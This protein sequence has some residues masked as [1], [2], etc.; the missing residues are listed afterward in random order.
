MNI[1]YIHVYI[2]T[3]LKITISELF[4]YFVLSISDAVDFQC[5]LIF[6]CVIYTSTYIYIFIVFIYVVFA[7]VL[8]VYLI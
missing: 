4:Y 8:G 2:E 7:G 6:L 3:F 1:H 5:L